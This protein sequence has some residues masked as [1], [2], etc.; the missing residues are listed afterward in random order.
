[1]TRQSRQVRCQSHEIAALRRA[2]KDGIA[3][4]RKYSWGAITGM[5]QEHDGTQNMK[6][7]HSGAHYLLEGLRLIRQPGLRRY[8]AIPLL[9]STIVFAGAIFGISYWLDSLINALL[10][11]LPSWLDWLR[12]LLWPLFTPLPEY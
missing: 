7:K 4:L 2:L 12:Y 1:M 3:I 11:Y 9:I 6:N 5:V 10:G 8:V